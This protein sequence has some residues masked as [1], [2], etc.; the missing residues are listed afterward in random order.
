MQPG[1]RFLDVGCGS[2]R[3]GRF[4]SQYV[5]PGNY[6]GIDINH[7]LLVAGYDAELDDAGQGPVAQ[8]EPARDRPL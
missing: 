3:A 4:I 6:Y 7:S 2:L 1:L 8:Q 5:D